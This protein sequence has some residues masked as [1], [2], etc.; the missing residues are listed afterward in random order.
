MYL[1]IDL[2][3]TSFKS[4]V[5]DEN[6][7][8]LSSA[9]RL[10]KFLSA[11]SKSEIS[12]T[13]ILGAFKE[14][15]SGALS[16][17]HI[18][19][20]KITSI[21]ITSQA[22]TFAIVQGNVF[23]THFISWMDKRATETCDKIS[24]EPIFNDFSRHA[25]F[26]KLYPNL[27]LCFMKHISEIIDNNSEIL[28][29]PSYLIKLLTGKNIT[30]NNIA[31]MSGFYSIPEKKW[32]KELLQYCGISEKQMPKLANI[33]ENI[34]P[35]SVE[36]LRNF[37]LPK[38]IPVFSC[39]NDQTA[40]AYGANIHKNNKILITL[41]TAQVAYVCESKISKPIEGVFRGPC[42]GGIY[43]KAVADSYGGAMINIALDV[44]PEF[45]DF[46]TFFKLAEKGR[47]K[48]GKVTVKFD[49]KTNQISRDGDVL[50]IEAYAYSVLD[51][52][53]ERMI[54]LIKKLNCNKNEILCSG[55]GSKNKIWI[56]LMEEKLNRKI[57][58]V[59][60][61]SLLG[62]ARMSKKNYRQEASAKV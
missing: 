37:G 13:E 8:K 6:L 4:A 62:V 50:D 52:I 45:K 15:I 26:D 47:E 61:D 54:V 39:G 44:I 9:S 31:A 58:V 29:L 27:Q 16:S 32:R 1:C 43:Y 49:E 36:S 22:Q 3:T 48:K 42:P 14:I 20:E 2:G 38:G 55:G 51:L 40:G 5:F 18:T 23:K 53:T 10:V 34:E 33:G 60:F 59:N 46:S 35:T 24:P 21:G 41:G 56:E 12:A 28:P 57:R 25:S 11:S 19:P 17:A 30:D 7:N